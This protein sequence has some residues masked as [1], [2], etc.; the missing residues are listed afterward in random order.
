MMLDTDMCLAYVNNQ[1]LRECRDNLP[2]G[3]G[4]WKGC[5]E[6]RDGRGEPLAAEST[7][8]CA[9]NEE[10]ILFKDGFL[11]NGTDYEFCGHPIEDTDR[12]DGTRWKCC[13]NVP[14][15][16]GSFTGDCDDNHHPMGPGIEHI[17]TYLDNEAQ[18]LADFSEAWNIATE[19]G[20][21]SL[22]SVTEVRRLSAFDTLK[23][24]IGLN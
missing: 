8:C 12:L 19:N 5:K 1:D 17:K 2:D 3:V 13:R 4:F 24:M 7:N 11:T 21:P 6:F 22:T 16:K 9:W 15:K 20:F 18:W 10:K 14:D 23:S